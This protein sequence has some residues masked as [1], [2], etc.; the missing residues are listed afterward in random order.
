MHHSREDGTPFPVEHC[1]I[2]AG[3]HDGKHVQSG[4]RY[5]GVRMGPAFPV[6]YTT[7]PI[8]NERER[9]NRERWWLSAT[10]P[11]EKKSE[12]RIKR[13]NR[14]YAMLS[15][16]NALIV[17][18]RERGELFSEACRIAVDAGAFRM[19]W[20][21]VIDPTHSTAKSSPGTAAKRLRRQDKAYGTRRH[22]GQRAA[23]LPCAAAVATRRSATISRPTLD[24][25]SA[26]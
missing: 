9:D 26:E 20:I 4:T 19:A 17:R 1:A 2:H 5:F 10:S 18:V 12:I 16:I 25:D 22:A 15:R 14:V 11:I 7:A 23:R 13:L 6:E 24:G 8:R 21:G 3:L